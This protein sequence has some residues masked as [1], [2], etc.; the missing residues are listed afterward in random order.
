MGDSAPRWQLDEEVTNSIVIR[1]HAAARPLKYA[2]RPE[3]VEGRSFQTSEYS[4]LRQAQHERKYS[5]IHSKTHDEPHLT[6][7]YNYMQSE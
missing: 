7:A 3:P 1:G 2:V 5:V 6:R 4:M